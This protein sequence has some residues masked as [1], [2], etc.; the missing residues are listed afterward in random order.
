MS[1]FR[2]FS[3][4]FPLNR[5]KKA[6][7]SVYAKMDIGEKTVQTPVLEDH[8]HRVMDM[9]YATRLLDHVLVT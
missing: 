2:N 1:L 9:E 6:I 4:L 7:G 5:P 3:I 8:D